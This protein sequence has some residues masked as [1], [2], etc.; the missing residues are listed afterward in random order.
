MEYG[1]HSGDS[2]SLFGLFLSSILIQF[3]CCNQRQIAF[4]VIFSIILL[5][6]CIWQ[7][8]N[9]YL[10]TQSATLEMQQRPLNILLCVPNIVLYP[11]A[12]GLETLI[13]NRVFPNYFSIFFSFDGEMV[14]VDSSRFDEGHHFS[15]NIT[16]KGQTFEKCVES[17][18]TLYYT[19]AVYNAT[20]FKIVDK[21]C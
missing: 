21:S 11:C 16:L 13:S 2:Q 4:R 10:A 15:I 17:P 9:I 1:P 18:I 5:N 8:S 3:V 20:S 12:T 6:H 14:L 19:F 7:R